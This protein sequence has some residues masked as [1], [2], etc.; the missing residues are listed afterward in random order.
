MRSPKPQ[1][2]GRPQGTILE[3]LEGHLTRYHSKRPGGADYDPTQPAF[4]HVSEIAERYYGGPVAPL[5]RSHIGRKLAL[6][7]G[8]V[9]APNGKIPRYTTALEIARARAERHARENAAALETAAW[10]DLILRAGE[11]LCK[12]LE[13]LHELEPRDLERIIHAMEQEETHP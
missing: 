13:R 4:F 3:A 1:K 8:V 6:M 7:P 11:A 2:L 9:K 5:Q 10:P 12:A